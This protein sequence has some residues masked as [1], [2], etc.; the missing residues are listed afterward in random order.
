MIIENGLLMNNLAI[1]LVNSMDL[2]LRNYC[3]EIIESN[4]FAREFLIGMDGFQIDL[5]DTFIPRDITNI[6]LE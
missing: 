1:Y 2:C 6:I 3:E 4:E 5:R